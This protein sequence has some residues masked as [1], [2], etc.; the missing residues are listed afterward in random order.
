M[1][2]RD[3]PSHRDAAI[4][5]EAA[6]LL[7]TNDRDGSEF[8]CDRIGEALGVW[9]WPHPIDLEIRRARYARLKDSY[10]SIFQPKKSDTYW[11]RL[12]VEN[13]HDCRILA[14]CFMAAITERP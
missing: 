5:R 3:T 7:E 2:A 12:W 10:A 14:L 11:G 13:V 4:Y 9:E 8:S 1:T 6:R